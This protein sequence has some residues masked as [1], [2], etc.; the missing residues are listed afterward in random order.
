M[1]FPQKASPKTHGFKAIAPGTESTAAPIP[2]DLGM[3]MAAG[4]ASC[5][6]CSLDPD[7]L[8]HLAEQNGYAAP[9]PTPELRD[10]SIMN[11][12]EDVLFTVVKGATDEE[13]VE[14]AIKRCVGTPVKILIYSREE[15]FNIMGVF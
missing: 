14:D 15:S 6:Y 9:A 12:K 2:D 10:A 11:D 4:L 7:L 8:Q 3:Q 13:L 1:M 5:G